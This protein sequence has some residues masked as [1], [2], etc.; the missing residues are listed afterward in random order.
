MSGHTKMEEH[1]KWSHPGDHRIIRDGD[2]TLIARAYNDRYAD[3]IIREH[4]AHDAL[5]AVCRNHDMPIC[6]YG[7]FAD[8]LDNLAEVLMD[9][10]AVDSRWRTWLVTKATNL[11]A[12][13]AKATVHSGPGE[14]QDDE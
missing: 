14:E 11:R 4:N 10:P 7:T 12:A 1:A 8:T 6:P 3:Q 9:V 5:L 13:V 2:G